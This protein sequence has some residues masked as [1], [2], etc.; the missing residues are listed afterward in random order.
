[1]FIMEIELGSTFNGYRRTMRFTP[2]LRWYQPGTDFVWNGSV[3]LAP[4]TVVGRP[5]MI[6]GIRL[7]YLIGGR[8]GETYQNQRFEQ[9][10]T[11]VDEHEW[12]I[13]V[14]EDKVEG[15]EHD[16]PIEDEHEISLVIQ[17]T[18][19]DESRAGAWGE[20]IEQW[21]NYK[22]D[23]I[24]YFEMDEALSESIIYYG[25]DAADAAVELGRNIP[26]GNQEV[27][28]NEAIEE[29][30]VIWLRMGRDMERYPESYD[31]F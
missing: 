2:G 24:E 27:L 10:E 5:S 12:R 13:S 15:N 17:D 25:P 7:S 28:R 23:K 29:S 1:S 22:I 11:R 4:D 3:G 6:A 26:S 8:S 18:M 31:A 16:P 20:Q 14:L 9:L 30:G 19:G 21:G